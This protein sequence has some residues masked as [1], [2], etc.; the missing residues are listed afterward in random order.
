[1]IANITL[2]AINDFTSLE[3]NATQIHVNGV[4]DLAAGL[5]PLMYLNGRG[6]ESIP[7]IPNMVIRFAYP[8]QS[9]HF[10]NKSADTIGTVLGVTIPPDICT[11]IKNDP[12][13]TG[14]SPPIPAFL[15][16]SYG[17]SGGAGSIWRTPYTYP[18]TMGTSSKITDLA[19]NV[20][21]IRMC[22][23][24]EAGVLVCHEYNTVSTVQNLVI[25]DIVT[26][27]VLQTLAAPQFVTG[28]EVSRPTEEL[29]VAFTGA[30]T[31][32]IDVYD[33][34]SLT[35]QR[36][37]YSTT[38]S[39]RLTGLGANYSSTHLSWYRM[40]SP[41]TMHRVP[42]DGSSGSSQI[43]TGNSLGISG[44]R[45]VGR[46]DDRAGL[47]VFFQCNVSDVRVWGTDYAGLSVPWT[48][49]TTFPAPGVSA[50]GMA[51]LFI[52]E[53]VCYAHQGTVR[54]CDY[55]GGNNSQLIPSVTGNPYTNAICW[56]Y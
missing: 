16:T 24:Q 42:I 23:D 7:L 10:Q 8:I 34:A 36:N 27:S 44:E 51:I 56:G 35:L 54:A 13:T 6:G 43:S 26:G 38:S 3:V 37:L 22:A 30:P 49:I 21:A 12:P 25:R 1:M 48:S 45:H 52:E 29:I 55:G 2:G 28:L 15:Y 19:S 46:G 39:I 20:I 50:G 47:D 5:N 33:Y 31:A 40:A 53:R 17:L 11:R 14:D 9:L 41:Y 32:R 18:S 4:P